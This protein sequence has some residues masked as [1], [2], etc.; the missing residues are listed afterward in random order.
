MKIVNMKNTIKFLTIFLAIGS[1]Y[2]KASIWEDKNSWSEQYEEEFSHWINSNKV[3][4]NIFRDKNSP[5]YGINTDCADTTY[6]LRAIF[7]FE[8]KLPFAIKD[9]TG[10]RNGRGSLF[11]NKSKNWDKYGDENKKLIKMINDLGESVGTENLAYF[12]SYPTTIKKIHPGSFF[13]YKLKA[14]HGQFIRH[15]YNIKGI[16]PVGTFDAIYSTQANKA[17]TLPLIRRKEIEFSHAPAKS[18]GFKRMRWPD[19][20]GKDLE[21]L[22]SEMGAS[23]EQYELAQKLGEIE[24]F[25]LIKKTLA[26]SNETPTE[27]LERLLKSACTEAQARVDYVNQG[28]QHLKETNNKCMDY[29]QFDAYSTPARDKNLKELFEKLKLAF[30]DVKKVESNTF[31]GSDTSYNLVA[32]IFE[33]NFNGQEELLS[34]CPISYKKDSSINLKN[35]YLRIENNQL[36]SHPNDT[37]EIRWG[38]KKGIKTNCKAWY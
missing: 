22:P 25:K 16:N 9:P 8:N 10:D 11:N 4:E 2:T 37:L 20:I 15:S 31:T 30:E 35:L 6:A 18:W 32:Q 28:I 36:S 33:E 14:N 7:A 38:E 24:F 29:E 1:N 27:K 26:K 21:K 19:Q 12:D 3:H 5:Y 23:L 34:F 13:M 17:K